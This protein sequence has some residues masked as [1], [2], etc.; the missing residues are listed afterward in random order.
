MIAIR[1]FSAPEARPWLYRGPGVLSSSIISKVKAF[2]LQ[3]QK[4]A[5]ALFHADNIMGFSKRLF[6]STLNILTRSMEPSKLLKC[7]C[8]VLFVTTKLIYKISYRTHLIK[9]HFVLVIDGFL[10]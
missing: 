9:D 8:G 6:Q 7:L 5:A 1:V 3:I 2:I 10:L 4:A